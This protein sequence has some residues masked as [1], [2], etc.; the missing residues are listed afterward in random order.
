MVPDA[1]EQIKEKR[2]YEVR[3][4]QAYYIVPSKLITWCV[5]KDAKGLSQKSIFKFNNQIKF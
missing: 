5:I 2:I 1:E 3:N 4:S